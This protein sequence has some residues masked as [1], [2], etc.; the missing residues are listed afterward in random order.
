MPCVAIQGMPM[1]YQFSR[2]AAFHGLHTPAQPAQPSLAGLFAQ[3]RGLRPARALYGVLCR[4]APAV[5]AHLAHAQLAVPPRAAPADRRCELRRQAA[6]RRLRFG[7]G[8]L[9]VLE[10]GQGPA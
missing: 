9:A 7:G 6:A 8:E 1:H 2:D 3:T 5:A 4:V 10:W